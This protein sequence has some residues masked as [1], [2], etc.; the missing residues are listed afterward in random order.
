MF[1]QLLG[2][3]LIW[4][5][6][7]GPPR[8]IFFRLPYLFPFHSSKGF[9]AAFKVLPATFDILPAAF[10]TLSAASGAFLAASESEALSTASEVF[11]A[12]QGPPR[13]P[14]HS[15]LPLRLS[16]VSSFLPFQLS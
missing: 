1:L 14:R 3:V 9:P 11:S 6:D 16:L 5:D 10:E 15:G 2:T 13:Y 7:H 8:G 4:D 12:L